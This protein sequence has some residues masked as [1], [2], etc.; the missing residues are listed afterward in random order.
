MSELI[1]YKTKTAL[2]IDDY[3]SMRSA[4]KM[5]LASFGLTKVDLAASGS[6]AVMRVRGTKYDVIISDYNLGEGRDGQQTL[7]EMRHR[8]LIGLETAYLMVTAESIYERVV[9]AAELAPDDYLIKPFNGE[10]MRTRLNAILYKKEVFRSVYRNFT[11]GNLEQSL[12]GCDA[13]LK[14]YPKFLVDALRFKGEVLIAMGNFEAAEMLY[15]QVI[16]MRAVPWSRLGLAKA[17]HLQR[18]DPA[19]EELLLDIANQHPELVASYDMLADVQQTQNKLKEAQY[20]LQRGVTVS[21]KSPRRQRRL[22]EVAYQ[23]GDLRC[24]EGAFKS[25]IDKGRNSIFLVPNDF[26]NLSR[27]HLEQGDAKNAAEVIVNN[28]KLLQ[29]SEEGRL[30]S[31]VALGRVSGQAGREQEA[32]GYMEEALRIKQTGARCAPEL[33]LDMV[34]TCLQAGMEQ[35]AAALL[36][37][38]ASN[39]HDSATLLDKAKKIYQE[40]GKEEAVREILAKATRQVAQLSKDGALLLQRG[41]LKQGVTK[42]MQAAAAAPRNP[43]VLMN[44]AWAVLR[45]I[46]Q[47]GNSGSLL[48]DAKRLLADAAYLLPEHPRLAGLQTM[49]RGVETTL[50]AQRRAAFNPAF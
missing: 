47:Q 29:E 20:T 7:E 48:E 5:A 32:R 40:A 19:A 38:V 21:A 26:A 22:G 2:V 16:S 31:A 37:E 12:E 6:E 11:Q 25:A 15:K 46:E 42:L 14:T 3:P 43:R 30:V 27:V 4:F 44:T 17:L 45:L 28:R 34:Q 9:A 1:D 36:E 35:E 8:A 24:A 10:I 41:D 39:A 13:I 50:A 23:N 18:K 49:L 33:A